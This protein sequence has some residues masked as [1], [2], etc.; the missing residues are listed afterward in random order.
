[1][2]TCKYKIFKKILQIATLPLIETFFFKDCI[3]CLNRWQESFRDNGFV[4]PRHNE[5]KWNA[6]L[7]FVCFLLTFFSRKRPKNMFF[8]P[9]KL[10]FL[11]S[12]MEQK[13]EQLN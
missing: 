9:S 7:M 10:I 3:T 13:N 2:K 6:P 11:T 8:K 12:S 1:M 5:S 4:L